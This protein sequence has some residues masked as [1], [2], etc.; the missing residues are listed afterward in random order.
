M[1]LMQVFDIGEAEDSTPTVSFFVPRSES[2]G[3]VNN[4]KENYLFR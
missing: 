2:S 1:L 3:Y 4:K